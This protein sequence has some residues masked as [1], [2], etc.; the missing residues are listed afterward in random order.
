MDPYMGQINLF[1]FNFAPQGWI[2]CDGTTLNIS[3]NQPLFSLIGVK[4]GGNGTTTFCVPDMT[5]S[6]IFSTHMRYYIANIG[7]YPSRN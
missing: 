4:F 3:T 2:A 7:L 1:A 5:P 6:N